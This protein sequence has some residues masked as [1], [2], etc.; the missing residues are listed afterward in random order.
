M[1]IRY[2]FIAGAITSGLALA[3][4]QSDSI[5][6]KQPSPTVTPHTVEKTV[7]QTFEPVNGTLDVLNILE[8][9][10]NSGEQQRA[11][12]DLYQ[13]GENLLQALIGF[14]C[15]LVM[16]CLEKLFTRSL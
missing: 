6:N 12:D 7:L 2:F 5:V 10:T 15:S 11:R 16:Y 9:Q 14:V 1:N 13:K 4:Q 3:I 8:T